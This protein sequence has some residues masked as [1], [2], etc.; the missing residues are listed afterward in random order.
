MNITNI[1]S[2]LHSGL[3]IVVKPNIV[4]IIQDKLTLSTLDYAL[5][6][7]DIHVL[8]VDYKEFINCSKSKG[9]IVDTKGIWK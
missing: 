7:A 4:E 2:Q 1:I 9:L 3:V 6:L 5:N 8:F